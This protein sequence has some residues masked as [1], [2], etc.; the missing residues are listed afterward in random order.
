MV[1][2]QAGLAPAKLSLET[3]EVPET[4][5]QVGLHRAFLEG[6]ALKLLYV[7]GPLTFRDLCA[8]MRLTFPIVKELVRHLR[9]EMLC[10]VSGMTKG[11]PD[12]IIT[13]EGRARATELFSQNQYYGPTPV[14]LEAY[15]QM[16]RQQSVRQAE[17]HP[18][19]VRRAFTHLVLDARILRKLGTSLNSGASIFLYGPT[20]T[21]KTTIATALARVLARSTVWIPYAVEVEGQIISVYD[22]H[23]H[24]KVDDPGT[25]AADGRWVLCARPTVVVGGELT[26]D[27]LELQLNQVTKFY[28]APLQMKANNGLLIIDDF[29]RQRVQPTELLNRWVVPL[30]RGIDFLTLAGGKKVEIPFELFVVFATNLEPSKLADAAFLRRIQTKVRI[31]PVTERQFHE[32]FRR[33]CA[34]ASLQCE[35]SLV[36]E[37]IDIIRTKF[38]EPLRPC[39]PRDIVN[40]IVW[41]ARYEQMKPFLDRDSVRYAVDAYF[42]SEEQE[43][44]PG[45][46]DVRPLFF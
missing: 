15:V 17:I 9:H 18:P 10:E 12:L 37:V 23:L 5:E 39:Y 35:E 19:D 2:D 40:Q 25:E 21:G 4:V 8:R 43:H 36:D 28:A 32:I 31:G 22:P 20:G 45:R 46:I 27:M 24:A 42:V 13:S 7:S 26:I 33:V 30:D 1:M 11:L 3:P 6:L 14:P 34:D 44:G 38:N 16:V 41:A 29:G